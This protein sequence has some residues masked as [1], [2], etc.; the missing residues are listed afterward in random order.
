MPRMSTTTSTL[1]W[2]VLGAG[3]IARVFSSALPGSR[4]GRLVA[5]ASRS[6]ASADKFG[7]EFNLDPSARHATYEALLNDDR[8]DAVYIATPHPMHAEWTI[9]CLEAGKHVLCEKPMTLNA[10][11]VTALVQTA[12]EQQRLLM[13]AFMYR[14]HP[15]TA[16]LVELIRSGA[17]GEVRSIEAAFCFNTGKVHP[18][19]RLYDPMLGGGGILDV[20]CYPMSLARL[21]AGAAAGKPFLDPVEVKATG[22]LCE[23]GVDVVAAAALKFPS[24]VVARIATG[25]LV[26]ES[27]TATVYGSEGSITVHTPWIPLKDGGT[28]TMTLRRNGKDPEAVEVTTD[29]PLYAFEIDA[30]GDAIAA[31]KLEPE[32]P[33]MTWADTLG[34]I[35]ALDRWRQEIGLTYPHETPAHNKPLRGSLRK[36][37]PS[38]M[39]YAPIPGV[40]LP[41]S[42]LIMGVDVQQRMIDGAVKYDDWFERGGNAFDSAYIYSGGKAEESLGAWIKS[43]GV[44]DQVVVVDKGLHTPQC[45]P[46]YVEPQ[47]NTSLERLQS[48]YIDL[49][50]MHRDNEDVPVGEFV[51]A[52]SHLIETG[53]AHAW[54][55]SNWTVERFEAARQYAQKH[56]K[57]APAVLNNNLSLARLITPVWAGCIAASDPDTLAYLTRTQTVHLSWSSQARGYFLSEAVRATLGLGDSAGDIHFASPENEQRRERAR[58]LAKQRG[59]EPINIAAAY[60]LCQPFPSFALIGVRNIEQTVSSM[61]A[62]DIKLSPEELDYLDLRRDAL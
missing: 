58:E 61:A 18:E 51:D 30:A 48:D 16:K 15:Q 22:V 47:F 23:T 6:Q 10:H 5:V 32:P 53:R 55:G 28:V 56:G 40:K 49:Y 4:T 38:A 12:R 20:G 35:A 33:A 3:R 24:G 27:N 59:V 44:R 7:D 39:Q 26:G 42:K 9:K 29:K 8:V 25:V 57:V 52:M 11:D 19:S 54:G 14:C 34:N 62:L 21:V 41:V 45:E 17:I 46:R 43:R 50:I 1:G 37:E 13:E 36:R 31:G 60:V 2:A